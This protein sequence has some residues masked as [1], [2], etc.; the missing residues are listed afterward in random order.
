MG[1]VFSS[2]NRNSNF[3]ANVKLNSILLVL[4]LPVLFDRVLDIRFGLVKRF[5]ADF[6]VFSPYSYRGSDP[7][8]SR[9]KNG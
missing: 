3:G 2:V 7:V 6:F 4:A 8:P 9:F 1:F 5:L